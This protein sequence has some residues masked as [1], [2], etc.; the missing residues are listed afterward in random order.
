MPKEKHKCVGK[1]RKTHGIG[2]NQCFNYAKV[3]R[4]GKWY[5]GIHDPI[6][7]AKRRADRDAM[8]EAEQKMKRDADSAISRRRVAERKACSSF[9][10]EALESGAIKELVEAVDGAILGF[11]TLD[12]Q[13]L[14]KLEDK[15]LKH[16][17]LVAMTIV[18]DLKAALAKLEEPK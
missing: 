1:M 15:K 16:V 2:W 4:D 14:P 12:E 18:R 11:E 17:H 9:S 13:F 5:C 3:E 10:T 6:A 7:W 8:W